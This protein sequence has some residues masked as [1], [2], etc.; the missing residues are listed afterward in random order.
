MAEYSSSESE[1]LGVTPST[2]NKQIQFHGTGS[3][4][5]LFEAFPV[6]PLP[7]T[8]GPPYV[9]LHPLPTRSTLSS[10][11]CHASRKL[12]QS[13]IAAVES[14]RV[15]EEKGGVCLAEAAG[16]R[17]C[18]APLQF[19]SGSAQTFLSLG[20]TAAKLFTFA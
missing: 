13:G 12:L 4:A 9:E 5:Q 1:F 10:F 3:P 7:A 16:E 17:C 14:L 15:K 6:P 11:C 19:A 18:S 20:V 8:K 2:E